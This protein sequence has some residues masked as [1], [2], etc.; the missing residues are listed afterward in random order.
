MQE[1]KFP[2]EMTIGEGLW[3]LFVVRQST[4]NPTMIPVGKLEEQMEGQI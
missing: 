4:G 1:S 2:R 3:G